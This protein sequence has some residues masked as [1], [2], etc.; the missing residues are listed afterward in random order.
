MA[1]SRHETDSHDLTLGVIQALKTVDA[2]VLS[3]AQLRRLY[4]ALV[5][6]TEAVHAEIDNRS[7][8][9][10]LGETVRMKID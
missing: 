4:A 5:N 2:R 10:N 9:E 7:A 6:T 1:N 3:Y 8:S